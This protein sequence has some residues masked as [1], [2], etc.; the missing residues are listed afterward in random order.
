MFTFVHKLKS[1]Q[2]TTTAWSTTP[3][4]P[5][6][7]RSREVNPIFRSQPTIGN[8]AVPQ[9]LTRNSEDVKRDDSSPTP[10]PRSGHDFSRI[11][12]FPPRATTRAEGPVGADH[13]QRDEV[14]V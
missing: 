7:A 2:P 1:T 4:R 12:I 9:L 3:G 8:Q 13:A 11:P 6:F 5:H 14:D 10:S